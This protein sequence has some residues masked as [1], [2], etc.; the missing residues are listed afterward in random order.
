MFPGGGE[1]SLPFKVKQ[2]NMAEGGRVQRLLERSNKQTFHEGGG[3]NPR[4]QTTEVRVDLP[5]R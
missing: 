4:P 3:A 2:I 1:A 5:S